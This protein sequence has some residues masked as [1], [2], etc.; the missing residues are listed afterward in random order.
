MSVGKSGSTMTAVTGGHSLSPA[1]LLGIARTASAVVPR[2]LSEALSFPS[3]N[4]LPSWPE[5][6][7]RMR[8][9]RLYGASQSLLSGLWTTG[10]I[11]LASGYYER[12]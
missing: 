6:Q 9:M 12:A 1:T 2:A 4:V 10:R 7:K 5:L 11:A 8:Y 3:P